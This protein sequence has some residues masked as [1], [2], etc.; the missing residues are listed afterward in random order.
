MSSL[1]AAKIQLGGLPAL[2]SVLEGLGGVTSEV[3]SVLV[4]GEAYLLF[5]CHYE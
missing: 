3:T 5:S 1:A 4:S 2:S